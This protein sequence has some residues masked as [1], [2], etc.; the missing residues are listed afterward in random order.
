MKKD[1]LDKVKK[2][3]VKY[4]K[5]I[6]LIIF[7]LVVIAIV[8]ILRTIYKFSIIYKIVENNVW[9][10]LGDN[11]KITTYD[12][13]TGKVVGTIYYKNG[14]KKDIYN[15]VEWY[16][17]SDEEMYWILLEQKEYQVIIDDL[18]HTLRHIAK[19]SL[20]TTSV[21]QINEKIQKSGA[22][23]S[24]MKDKLSTEIYN[25]KEF[26]YIDGGFSR[27]YVDKDDFLIKYKKFG[28]DFY[29]YEIELNS[30]TDADVEFPD[31]TGYINLDDIE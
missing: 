18:V 14:I 30:V 10:E 15:G 26:F 11:Y 28:K 17:T 24:R 4:I 29:R 2:E 3:Y 21:A 8:L 16:T 13:N 7:V 19:E 6:K 12:E 23:K 20:F 9:M 22:I 5:I 25:N 1:E 27:W 31:L